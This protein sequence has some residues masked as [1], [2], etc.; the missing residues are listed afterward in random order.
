MLFDF[1]Y[2][3]TY[4]PYAQKHMYSTCNC[5]LLGTSAKLQKVTSSF[6]MSVCPS[7]GNNSAPTGWILIKFDAK[8]IF[9]NLSKKFKFH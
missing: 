6:V 9:E 4:T 5:P 1:S 2:Y 3:H 7:T 8:S